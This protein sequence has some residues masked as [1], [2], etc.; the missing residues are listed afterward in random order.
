MK[1]LTIWQPWATLISIGVKRYELRSWRTNYRGPVFIHAASRMTDAQILTMKFSPF[2]E[3][4]L[5]RGLDWNN[6]P[7]GALLCKTEIVDCVAASSVN[8]RGDERTLSGF[9]ALFAP[10]YAFKLGA[11][12][13]FPHPIPCRG[14]QGLW[15]YKG[16][17]P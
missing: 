3:V 6:L 16:Q 12:K 5:S 1:T 8:I 17:L 14:M 9:D 4:L 11:I 7:V 2:R 15:D 13:V 10:R